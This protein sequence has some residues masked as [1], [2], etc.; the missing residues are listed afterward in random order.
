MADRL[1]V[2]FWKVRLPERKGS[3]CRLL[4]VGTLN[5]ALV[6]FLSDGRRVVTDRRAV[7][8]VR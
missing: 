6:E 2:W 1:Y 8:R 7:R 5:S 3:L 4:C